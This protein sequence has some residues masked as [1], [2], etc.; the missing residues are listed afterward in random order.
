VHISI[1]ETL[2][3]SIVKHV[4][5]EQF[6]LEVLSAP[7]PVLVDF[8]ATWCPPCRMIAPVLEE[9]AREFHGRVKIVKVNV[10]EESVLAERFQ[11]RSV[12]T[13]L[14]FN[15]GR[16]VEQMIGVPSPTVLREKLARAS[17][18]PRSRVAT[19]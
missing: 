18:R 11:I 14:V 3:M 5:T 16:V 4:T 1:E 6:G 2:L 13:L 9:L 7:R 17:S 15:A 19:G 12:P 8:Y 10:D